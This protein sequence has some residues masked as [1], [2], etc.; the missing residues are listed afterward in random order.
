[1]RLN[2]TGALV[3]EFEI[4]RRYFTDCG[5]RRDDV[6]VGI[7]DDGAVLRLP[8][9]CELV[10]VMDTMVSGVH[11]PAETRAE[12][13]G[14]KALAVNLSDM[15]AMG[16]EPAW[17]TLALTLPHPDIAWLE[18]FARGISAAAR[19]FGV[20]LVGGDTTRG[21]LTVTVQLQG[22]V[23]RGRAVR[24]AGA[25]G[26]DL[27]CVTGCLGDA[28]LALWAWQ[29]RQTLPSPH[30]EYLSARL[31]RPVP[32]CAEGIALR[33][34]ATAMIDVSDGL[35]AD[36]GHL[37]A[38]GGV[39]ATLE[40]PQLPLSESFRAVT[41]NWPEDEVLRLA[42][43]GGDDY[44]LCFTLPPANRDALARS[45]E[46]FA[47]GMRVIGVIDAAPGLRGRRADGS[48]LSLAV[49]GYQHFI[50]DEAGE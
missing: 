31:Y 45:F 12:D 14:Y 10:T 20:Q 40:L 47:C 41:R 13:V 46:R 26:G 8:A 43:S 15:A 4:I 37:L 49:E 29:R 39:G 3:N 18:G 7:G 16:A 21:P 2:L 19:A 28:A 36:L 17:A 22:W 48:L 44:E 11:F 35:A 27:V 23:P 33:G 50:P 30:G 5:V 42:L 25:R 9:E 1:L 34:V 6:V 38:A 32:R 24:R